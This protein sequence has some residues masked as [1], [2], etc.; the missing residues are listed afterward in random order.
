MSDK[1]THIQQ[2]R[3]AYVRLGQFGHHSRLVSECLL[4]HPGANNLLE[5]SGEIFVYP[6]FRTREFL[7]LSS[8][9]HH[10]PE[11]PFFQGSYALEC[12]RDGGCFIE[13]RCLVEFFYLSEGLVWRPPIWILNEESA[14]VAKNRP[15]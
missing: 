13:S 15:N 11:A 2:L 12:P 5:N 4:R 10:E 6:L 3:G 7:L 8:G 9:N 1:Y 14:R